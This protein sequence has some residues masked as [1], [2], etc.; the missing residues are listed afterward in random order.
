MSDYLDSYTAEN[1]F[2]LKAVELPD[3]NMIARISQGNNSSSGQTK[4]VKSLGYGNKPNA[5]DELTDSDIDKLY[6][7][8]LLGTHAPLPL[9]N[10]L[11]L[12]LTLVLGMRG[13]KEQRDLKFGDICI[14]VDSQ[15]PTTSTVSH[16]SC[17]QTIAP[18]STQMTSDNRMSSY[19]QG[20]NYINGG[21]FNFFSY[22]GND[23]RQHETDSLP[24]QAPQKKF[25]RILPYITFSDDS[26]SD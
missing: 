22:S 2:E 15:A 18:V 23:K 9:T 4:T 17:S 6:E 5:S 25:K 1:D 3:F 10:L 19:F 20:N 11:H 24:E 14:G 16:P 26:D 7:H 21:T 8:D 13:G 12:T